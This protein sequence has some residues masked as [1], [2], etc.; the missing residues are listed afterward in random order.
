VKA[1]T[2]DDVSI[3]EC[4]RFF[5]EFTEIPGGEGDVV[6]GDDDNVGVG[7]V[8]DEHSFVPAFGYATIYAVGMVDDQRT[9]RDAGAGLGDLRIAGM[10]EEMTLDGVTI[11][12]TA[13]LK[14]AGGACG[15][16]VGDGDD[17]DLHLTRI[18]ISQ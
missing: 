17:G 11:G 6:V 10:Q 7:M 9:L 4:R 15:R 8:G 3:A 18:T 12:G 1:G 14:H 5:G 2:T 13:G 16:T